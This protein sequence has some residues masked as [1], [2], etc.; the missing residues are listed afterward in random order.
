MTPRTLHRY[1]APLAAVTLLAA[2]SKPPE[3]PVSGAPVPAAPEAPPV[4]AAA[5][6]IPPPY[7]SF[8][9]R[10]TDAGGRILRGMPVRVAV[11]I[12]A[13][14]E[15]EAPLELAPAAGSWVDAVSVEL[16]PVA[17]PG[18]AVSATA[19]GQPDAPSATLAADRLT[20]GLWRFTAA[21]TQGLEP[22]E[23]RLAVRLAIPVG[24][25]WT[26]EVEAGA[27]PVR[28][29]A[30]SDRPEDAALLGLALAQDALLDERLEDAARQLDALLAAQRDNLRAW[31]LR[32]LVAERA[33]NPLSALA[34]A[35][36]ARRIHDTRGGGEPHVVIESLYA[37]VLQQLFGTQAT[38]AP[39][40]EPPPWSRV[41]PELL[42]P[43]DAG[44]QAATQATPDSTVTAG[45]VDTPPSPRT[46][47]P[48]ASA[49]APPAAQEAPPPGTVLA[50]DAVGETEILAD[51]RGQ[52][53]SAARASTEYGPADYSAQQ[54]TGAPDVGRYGDDACAWAPSASERQVEWLELTFAKPVRASEVRVRQSYTPGTIVKVEAF[55]PDGSGRVLW[56]GRD[57]NVY[58]QGR[59]AWFLLR[60]PTTA[61]P[62]ARVR[63]TLDTPAAK[64]WKEIDAVQLV[65]E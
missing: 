22:G 60:V 42:E 1:L 3:G 44:Q 50:W 29:A 10:D 57:A 32:G 62:V 24:R 28:V 26:G 27:V 41:P 20:G 47:A 64:G 58:P 12:E 7:V 2:C 48:E 21:Q 5:P 49:P 53:A 56:S 34:C 30:A 51:A 14:E 8:T 11:S 4:A 65:G 61:Q 37:R 46:V 25:G 43:T 59:I 17:G 35:N 38:A 23:Y 45:A 6:S 36:R 40:G 19:V 9:L 54:A 63:I 16:R 15:G 31:L 52:W 13:P 18:A 39:M 55:A 33:G